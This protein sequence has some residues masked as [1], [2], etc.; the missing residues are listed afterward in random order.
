MTILQFK[1]SYYLERQYQS[2]SDIEFFCKIIVKNKTTHNQITSIE[3]K[4]NAMDIERDLVDSNFS[5]NPITWETFLNSTIN[6]LFNLLM[7]RINLTGLH[8]AD[9]QEKIAELFNENPF[10]NE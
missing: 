9:G 10:H 2:V 6:M 1:Q 4:I 3:T 5:I 7:L 8:S